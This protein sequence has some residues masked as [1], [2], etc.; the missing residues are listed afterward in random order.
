[1]SQH[2]TLDEDQFDDEHDSEDAHMAMT[3]C[4]IFGCVFLLCGLTYILAM[5]S[6]HGL[7]DTSR[8]FYEW[9]VELLFND[10]VLMVLLTLIVCIATL[11][12]VLMVMSQCVDQTQVVENSMNEMQIEI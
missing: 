12:L 4:G 9:L 6:V 2:T 7:H 10:A 5:L 1:M 11:V 3:C 8:M